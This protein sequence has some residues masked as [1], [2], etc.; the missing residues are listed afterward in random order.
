[1]W[2]VIFLPKP[3]FILL[4]TTAVISFSCKK[5]YYNETRIIHT[6]SPISGEWDFESIE[7]QS[8]S[9]KEYNLG[10]LN[11][12]SETILNYTSENN[13]GKLVITDS[14][15]TAIELTYTVSSNIKT[16]T[17]TNGVLKD[18]SEKP[19]EISTNGR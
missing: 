1:M 6:G 15:L 11:H 17:Y 12:K 7:V 8:Q 18:S 16:Y 14:V 2:K 4:L 9:S 19:Y 5:H 3:I 10:S 13:S